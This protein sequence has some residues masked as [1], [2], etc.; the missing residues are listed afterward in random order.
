MVMTIKTLHIMT[1]KIKTFHVELF[2]FN[3]YA[4][5]KNDYKG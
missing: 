4:V 3:M 5:Y 1:I 2:V